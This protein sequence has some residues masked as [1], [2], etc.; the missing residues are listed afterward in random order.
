MSFVRKYYKKTP[1]YVVESHNE[2]LPLIYRCI[3]SKHLPFEGNTMI[4]LDSHPDMLASDSMLADVVS[5]KHQLFDELSIGDWILPAMYA[6][7]LKNIIW[8]KPPW[9]N[10]MTDGMRTFLIGKDKR[11][12]LIRLTCPEP[13]FL[14]ETLYATPDELENIREATLHVITIGTFIE[15]STNKDDFVTIGSMLRQYLPEKD[16]PYI[17]DIDLDFFSTRNPFKTLYE[18]VNLYDKLISIFAYKHPGSDDPEI[19]KESREERK[20]QLSELEEIFTHLSQ[21]RS[22][23]GFD[24]EKTAIYEAVDQLFQELKLAYPNLD[25][26]WMMV[27]T[28]G[29]TVDDQG[30]PEHV[31]E[32]NDLDRL[33]SGTFRSFLAALPTPPTIV[34]IARSSDDEYT[35]PES[36]DQIQID[37][38]DQLGERIEPEV[39]V[40][41]IYQENQEQA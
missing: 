21:N 37:V 5:N 2:V 7:H 15:D 27:Y 10:Q 24:G 6:G 16:T 14:S 25:I 23:K 33:I 9:A 35:P 8:V 34:T 30:L 39:D 3:G 13:Y 40:Q 1:V 19:L 36:V 31:T 28:A 17:L 41:L 22:L 18:R 29:L 4:H 20:K 38:L 26:D 11:T 12:E 32:P